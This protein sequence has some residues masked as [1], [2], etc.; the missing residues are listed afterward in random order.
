MYVTV[1]GLS[2]FLYIQEVTGQNLGP[3]SD[4]PD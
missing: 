3:E 2:L 4:Y 1:E